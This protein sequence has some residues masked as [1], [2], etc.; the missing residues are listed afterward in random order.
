MK[1]RHV[2][3]TITEV[4]EHIGSEQEAD[5]RRRRLTVKIEDDENVVIYLFSQETR[6]WEVVSMRRTPAT[7]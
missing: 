1:A 7:Q 5:R 2:A 4:A 3:K 6:V